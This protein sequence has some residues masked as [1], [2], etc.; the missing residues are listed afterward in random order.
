MDSSSMIEFLPEES[1]EKCKGKTAK[2]KPCQMKGPYCRFHPDPN[3]QA[4]AV[5]VKVAPPDQKDDIDSSSSF[6]SEDEEPKE[7]CKGVTTKGKPCQ[8]SG[9]YCQFHKKCK[10]DGCEN[11]SD[12]AEEFC[13][14]HIEEARLLEQSI[15]FGGR[16]KISPKNI[17]SLKT[18]KL[19]GRYDVKEKIGEGAF[20]SVYKVE[21]V[22]TKKIYAM[23]KF[24]AGKIETHIRE[25]N[26]MLQIKDPCSVQIKDAFKVEENNK[27][28]V[29]MDYLKGVEYH[30][31][32]KKYYNLPDKDLIFPDF[33]YLYNCIKNV[34]KSNVV[35]RD[36]KLK[37]I[38][39][40]EGG[41]VKLID[42][43]L[44]VSKTIN[45]GDMKFMA[46]TPSM[47]NSYL[48]VFERGYLKTLTEKEAFELWKFNDY[49]C[50]IASFYMLCA[51]EYVHESFGSGELM[52]R[53]LMGIDNKKVKIMANPGGDIIVSMINEVLDNYKREDKF[54][55]VAITEVIDFYIGKYQE[56]V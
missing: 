45:P 33:I 46:G 19:K 34:H 4:K 52:F 39:K 31:L 41:G 30:D 44:A 29:I 12:I 22:K 3:P 16:G 27:Y 6:E 8:M 23:K 5:L 40:L 38:I 55:D 18:L 7:L 53:T 35:H 10:Y 48:H 14:D 21:N 9:P 28:C 42:F 51:G 49:W 2:G 24:N 54:E 36:I 25:I 37:N 1:F 11:P 47:L 20:A 32:A 50:L 56:S 13:R 43:G 17:S 26:I 15:S